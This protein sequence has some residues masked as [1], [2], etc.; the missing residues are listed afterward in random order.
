MKL[1]I[2]NFVIIILLSLYNF[3]IQNGL[4]KTF[5]QTYFNYND[6][7]RPLN[8]CNKDIECKKLKCIGMP[9]G[10][11]ETASLF[12]ILLYFNKFINLW[13]CL[14]SIIFFSAQRIITNM[15]TFN[16]VLIG[17]I[18]GL[19]YAIIYNY[20]NL[21]L[22]G[23][24]FIFLIGFILSILCIYKIDK[25]IK[26]PIPN[27]VDK[28]MYESIK[29]KQNVPLYIKL[30]SLY[31][32]SAIQ[33]ITY[34]NWNTLEKYL[35]KIVDNIKKGETKYDA[36][37][38]IKTGGAIISDYIS[39]KLGLPN[40]KIKLTR[41]E[42]NCKK[43]SDNTIDDMVK[44]NLFKS[45]GGYTICEGINDNLEGKKIILI[46]ELVSTGKTMEESYNYLK[47]EKNAYIVYPTCISFY[48][49]KYRGSLKINNLIDGTIIVWPW[50]YDN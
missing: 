6:V 32:N 5:T 30:G 7:K 38:G 19:I 28:S 22:I 27:W 3:S 1:N 43:T 11:A 16:Q 46:D 10:H 24:S 45:Q 23:F 2:K 8:I 36:V 33:S 29:N 35:D 15:H 13:V 47:R 41:E 48:K 49:S 34:I 40:Y 14:F 26:E 17:A 21:S 25:N 20:F 12:F 9:S 18:L 44:K 37:V 42:Y 4:E 39:L 31:I 50:G